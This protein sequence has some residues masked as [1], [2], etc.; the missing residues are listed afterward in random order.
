MKLIDWILMWVL[1]P[2]KSVMVTVKVGVMDALQSW[3]SLLRSVAEWSFLGYSF[4]FC[5]RRWCCGKASWQQCKE[6]LPLTG[7]VGDSPSRPT[8]TQ[9]YPY[10]A[11][12]QTRLTQF[13][14]NWPRDGV[15][16]CNPMSMDV[17]NL[18]NVR[19][20]TWVCAIVCPL[21]LLHRHLALPEG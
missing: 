10:P 20:A 3:N 14:H 17:F 8:P 15:W 1:E 5:C 4:E 11:P 21:G 12:T 18:V 6:V 19:W 16:N 7:S 13:R 2:G 9:G